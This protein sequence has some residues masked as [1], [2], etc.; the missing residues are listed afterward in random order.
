MMK[1]PL[2]SYLESKIACIIKNNSL[3]THGN[4]QQFLCY[5]NIV[6]NQKPEEKIIFI[7]LFLLN[8][9]HGITEFTFEQLKK[10]HLTTNTPKK[11]NKQE[12]TKIDCFQ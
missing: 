2:C 3:K 5:P 4:V 6:F 10:R 1:L 9:Q 12:I 7:M 8:A 11:L